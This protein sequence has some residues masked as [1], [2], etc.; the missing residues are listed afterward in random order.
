MLS[1]WSAAEEAF[2]RAALAAASWPVARLSATP[3]PE[4]LRNVVDVLQQG[5]V[6][7][8]RLQV[9]SYNRDAM[10]ESV[11]LSGSESVFAVLLELT[12]LAKPVEMPRLCSS[13]IQR[14]SIDI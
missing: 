2:D 10:C 14:R 13:K 5:R 1:R 6:V 12:E 7:D 8:V 9:V 4:G 11:L 3:L